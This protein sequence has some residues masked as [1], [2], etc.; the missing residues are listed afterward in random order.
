MQL[1][2]RSADDVFNPA[3]SHKSTTLK[4]YNSLNAVTNDDGTMCRRM[5]TLNSQ[6]S[7]SH[8]PRLKRNTINIALRQTVL[9]WRMDLML[10]SSLSDPI[11]I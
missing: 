11:I 1:L 10:A 6:M 5:Q 2:H 4:M 8:S 7:P 3:A 9:I